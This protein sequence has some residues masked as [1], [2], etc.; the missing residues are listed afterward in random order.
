M[1]EVSRIDPQDAANAKKKELKLPDLE[2][3]D[4][5]I[6]VAAQTLTELD[7]YAENI[8]V[9]EQ[10]N[11]Q[12]AGDEEIAS[13]VSDATYKSHL[14]E[15][16]AR[17]KDSNELYY[18]IIKRDQNVI[19][20]KIIGGAIVVTFDSSKGRPGRLHQDARG[21]ID[22]ASS[23]EARGENDGIQR[24][25]F[26][27]V[28][29]IDLNPERRK[30][31]IP[32]TVT[33]QHEFRHHNVGITDFLMS[34]D[35][36]LGMQS[37]NRGG[38][39]AALFGD[40]PGRITTDQAFANDL[41]I[42]EILA[43][44]KL[45][46][47]QDQLWLEN[48]Q[49]YLDELHP[50]F[51]QRKEN[52]FHAGEVVYGAH[53]KG[54]HWELVGKN[55]EDI[56]ASKILFGYLQVFWMLNSVKEVMAQAENPGADQQWLLKEI[57]ELFYRVGGKIGTARTIQQAARLVAEEWQNFTSTDVGARLVKGEKFRKWTKRIIETA[58]ETNW[59]G[60]KFASILGVESNEI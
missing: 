54:K 38:R 40:H 22:Q 33:V 31:G 17:F 4:Q 50:S 14:E 49:Y 36:E 39:K 21:F 16:L 30:D 12:L 45:D 51:L 34:Q 2:R 3:L 42:Y 56:E 5:R 57:P 37:T 15:L 55:P 25:Y 23:F 19:D 60:E 28:I 52:W 46:L 13:Q 44:R 8:S 18:Q 59:P 32:P 6:K 11:I 58:P 53:G 29:G 41:P 10:G 26:L 7:K 1:S 47:R 9:D 48:Q 20:A 43:G 24:H 27:A 35:E